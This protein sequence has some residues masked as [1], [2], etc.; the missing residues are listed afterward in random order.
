MKTLFV[1]LLLTVLASAQNPNG[2]RSGMSGV[3][4]TD[5]AVRALL[6]LQ[7]KCFDDIA[8]R[9]RAGERA[10]A[11]CPEFDAA[12]RR[13]PLSSVFRYELIAEP[14]PEDELAI[15]YAIVEAAYFGYQLQRT[16][17]R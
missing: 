13:T 17:K 9:R 4:R 15:K 11:E 16:E 5:K 6:E 7:L 8:R 12:L 14:S 3:R 2:Q 1:I 10:L